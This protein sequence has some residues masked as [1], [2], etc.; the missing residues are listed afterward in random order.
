M[1]H[2]TNIKKFNFTGLT[3][4][5]LIQANKLTKLCITNCFCWE[6][7][8][9]FLC[10]ALIIGKVSHVIQSPR[11][12]CLCLKLLPPWRWK[13]PQ[14]T[15]FQFPQNPILLSLTCHNNHMFFS[16]FQFIVKLSR[17]MYH[18]Q[19]YLYI[20]THWS[21][22]AGICVGNLTIIGSDNGLSPGR[23]QAIIWNN[24]GILS[25]GLLGTNFSEILIE[26]LTFSLKKMHLKVSSAKWQPFC[27]VLN[28]L[29]E[30][31]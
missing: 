14:P 31:V 2:H 10:Q 6:S 16:K 30:S 25:I 12:N 24:A 18:N 11:M 21:W 15:P 22:V 20:F 4:Q 7:T 8:V 26:I 29:R 23:R 28:V 3:I 19:S 5:W 13:V 1:W 27:L 9:D 17:P